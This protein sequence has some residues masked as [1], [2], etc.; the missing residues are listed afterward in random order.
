[1]KLIVIRHG[2]TAANEQK[3][4]CGK[5]DI[6]LSPAGKEALQNLRF[7]T[8]YPDISGFKVITSGMQRCEQTLTILFGDVPHQTDAAFREMDFGAFEMKSFEQL[9]TDERY[10]KWIAGDNEKKAPPGGESGV[11]MTARV[12]GALD[13]LIA[14]GQ[15]TLLV[16]HGGV[17]AAIMAHLFPEEQKT[18]YEWQPEPGGGYQIDLGTKKYETFA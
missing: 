4:Y 3:Q 15:D 13:S 7:Q 9:K 6:G 16:T 1:M 8:E 17:I 2:L 10:L 14:Q 5:T 12:I 11:E 18:R